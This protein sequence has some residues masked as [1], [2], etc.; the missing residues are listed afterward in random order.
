MK[1]GDA[2]AME[3][4]ETNFCGIF[5]LMKKHKYV[6]IVLNQME[7][8]YLNISYS[9]LQEI[10]MN[11]SCRY[12]QNIPTKNIY[13]P[14]HVL[15]EVMENV[16]MWVKE[17]P[18]HQDD[19]SWTVHSPNVTFAR[20]SITFEKNEYKR[21]SIDFKSLFEDGTMKSREVNQNKYV[22][23]RKLVEK[24]RVFEFVTKFLGDESEAQRNIEP[25][26]ISDIS[27]NLV[28]LLKKNES[29]QDKHTDD[30]DLHSIIDN[31][32]DSLHSNVNNEE[33]IITPITNDD[34][35]EEDNEIAHDTTTSTCDI[36]SIHMLS[37]EDILEKGKEEMRQ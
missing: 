10:R 15:D 20:R 6:E 18:V 26:F 4:I 3:Y 30:P 9:Q 25:S 19:E 17:L 31:I 36:S 24:Q 22:E 37:L 1:S 29:R 14:M 21:S 2:V 32:D 27:T 23:P 5:H 33:S 28:T 12:E 7:K 35:D 11:C 8:K 13:Y 34:G 16:N